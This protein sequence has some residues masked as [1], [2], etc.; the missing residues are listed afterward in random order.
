MQM[1]SSLEV[2]DF[3][4]TSKDGKLLKTDKDELKNEKIFMPSTYKESKD[5]FGIKFL[6]KMNVRIY[7]TLV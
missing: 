4:T 1:V 2:V 3:N 7:N 6:D 5:R